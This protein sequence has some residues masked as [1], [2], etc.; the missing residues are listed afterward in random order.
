MFLFLA[1][2][3]DFGGHEKI[4]R[5]RVIF[6]WI[7]P[8]R[9]ASSSWWSLQTI[10]FVCWRCFLVARFPK[11]VH[12]LRCARKVGPVLDYNR[13]P[14]HECHWGAWISGLY[15]VTLPVTCLQ[16]HLREAAMSWLLV[17]YALR[18]KVV[19]GRTW[20]ELNA[21]GHTYASAVVSTLVHIRGSCISIGVCALASST[22]AS[23]QRRNKNKMAVAMLK[24]E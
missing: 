17:R 5:L 1:E 22:Q 9:G 6:Q 16:L 20:L 21:N 8:H 14:I 11:T 10:R 15:G 19:L 13:S 7:S 24:N 12:S 4:V 18:A 23:S 2:S 3:E